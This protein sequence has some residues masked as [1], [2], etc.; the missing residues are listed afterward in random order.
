MPL[1]LPEVPFKLRDLLPGLP[2]RDIKELMDDPEPGSEPELQGILFDLRMGNL[3]GG[4]AITLRHV[5]LLLA[6]WPQGKPLSIMDLATGT[7]DTPLA[8]CR[9]AAKAGI[10]LNMVATDGN[11]K[12][13]E[14]ARKF[15]RG[16][17][18]LQLEVQDARQLPYRDGSFDVC[19]CSLALHHFTRKD[20]IGVLREMA[21]VSRVGF[22]VNDLERG[23]VPY[24]ALRLASLTPLLSKWARHDGPVS[25]ARAYTPYEL[26]RMAHEAGVQDAQVHRHSFWRQALVGRT[27]QVPEGS[28]RR[29]VRRSP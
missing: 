23:I 6:G 16:R 4:T 25:V 13:L 15:V 12:V 17:A 20:A 10:P 26:A 18:V 1:N 28:S 27:P 2:Y 5:Q 19:T 7:A 14:A 11:P 29:D 24:A 9:W 8:I 22:V 21:R 3:M